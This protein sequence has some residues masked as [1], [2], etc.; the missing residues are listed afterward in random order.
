M[1]FQR[2]SSLE[3]NK[4]KEITARKRNQIEKEFMIGDAPEVGDIDGLI[5]HGSS[6]LE[7]EL[8]YA[9]SIPENDRVM[10]R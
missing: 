5:I 8:D 6:V 4:I 1:S 7:K 2:K 3:R 10:V 9:W